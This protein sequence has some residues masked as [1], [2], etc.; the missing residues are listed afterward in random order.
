MNQPLASLLVKAAAIREASYDSKTA[1]EMTAKGY[2]GDFSKFYK[3][4]M[5]D[6]AYEACSPEHTALTE[7]VYL[8]LS[9]CWNDALEWAGT[10][11]ND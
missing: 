8:L 6:A 11:L 2:L 9:E 5:H 7:P 3:K 1:D 4:S 10:N